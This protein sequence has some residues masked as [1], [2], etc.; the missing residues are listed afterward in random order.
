M[1]TMSAVVMT[2][3]ADG[4]GS[5]VWELVPSGTMPTISARSPMMFAAIEVIGATVVTTWRSD[6][7]AA[8][9]PDDS[10]SL[11]GRRCHTRR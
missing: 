1:N 8:A 10:A 3:A 9:V 6:V 5:K 4:G 2:S 7:D 11:D